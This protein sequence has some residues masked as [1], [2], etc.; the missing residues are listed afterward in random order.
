M[1]FA[2]WIKS[3]LDAIDG[4]ERFLM[5]LGAGAVNT[6]LLIG[7]FIDQGTYAMLTGGTVVAYIGGVALDRRPNAANLAQA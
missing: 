7:G 5:T 1:S 6:C 2:Q 4:D 3:L